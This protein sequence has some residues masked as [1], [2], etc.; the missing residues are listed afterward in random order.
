MVDQYDNPLDLSSSYRLC[1]YDNYSRYVFTNQEREYFPS[2]KKLVLENKILN[3]Q[4]TV[5]VFGIPKTAKYDL[6]K[7]YDVVE[8][9]INSID[10]MAERYDMLFE[11]QVLLVDKVKSIVY[12]T[13][14]QVD[15]YQL[16]IVDY[17]KDNSY[18]INYHYD[19]HVYE[20]DISSLN[21]ENRMIYDSKV[22]LSGDKTITQVRDYKITSINGNT[23]GYVV[24]RKGVS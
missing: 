2:Q 7:I 11:S 9:N 4:D 8:D 21:S 23:N 20:V 18:C 17:L 6:D 14:E 22:L 13:P 1:H 10:L 19:K 16:I 24:I 12:L 15:K 3:K 5:R